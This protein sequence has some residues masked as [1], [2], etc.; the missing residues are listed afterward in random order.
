MKTFLAAAFV[1][2][3]IGLGSDYLMGGPV[4]ETGGMLRDN[5]AA[6]AYVSP[7]V[8]LPGQAAEGAE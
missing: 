4:F 7:N 5:S 1:V 3:G 8:R 2:A 6:A